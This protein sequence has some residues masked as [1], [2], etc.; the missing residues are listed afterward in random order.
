MDFSSIP[1][2]FQY[3]WAEGASG[4]YI[5]D[6]I[7]ATASG[8]AASQTLGFPPITATA[9]GAGGIPPNIA[10]LNGFMNYAAAWLQ[11]YQAGGAI[12]YDA[13]LSSWIGGY[14]NNAIVQSTVTPGLLWQSTADNNTT[15]PDSSSA[16]NWTP[17]NR[18]RCSANLNLYIAPTGSDTANNGLSSGSPFATL[19]HAINVLQKYY[20]G[21]GFSA[22]INCANGSYLMTGS[23]AVLSVS[24]PLLGFNGIVIYGN[25]I[26]PSE[27]IF[28]NTG[29]GDCF[30]IINAV[31]T[32]NGITFYGANRGLAALGGAIVNLY[33]FQVGNCGDYQIEAATGAQIY[34]NGTYTILASS[35]G[36]GF[37]HAHAGGTITLN[38]ATCECSAGISYNIG[39]VVSDEC[40]VIE[41]A[42]VTFGGS[43]SSVVGT[44]YQANIN[45]VI[46]TEGGG[47]NYFPG[48]VAGESS[49]G[50]VYV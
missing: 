43:S 42:Y 39:F 8:G 11:W 6:P 4:S 16:A 15:N 21:N 44:R 23:S 10:D 48:S 37:A 32:F 30:V 38:S 7:P 45:G 12:Q 36:N 3:V 26:A 24:T 50:G 18:I 47:A 41:A 19:Q 40:G 17:F 31:I 28:A 22:Q 27:V 33:N 25:P 20:D 9:T 35:G 5:T 29:S 49:S 14:A 13:T 1:Y 34:V 46:N 2:K